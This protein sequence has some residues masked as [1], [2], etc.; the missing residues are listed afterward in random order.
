MGDPFRGCPYDKSLLLGFC[1][2]A[3]D[4]RNSN[5]GLVFTTFLGRFRFG[6]VLGHLVGGF[7][8]GLVFTAFT[9]WVLSWIGAYTYY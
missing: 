9:R 4:F 8:V 6:L 7:W 3:P 5:F 2:G 1:I